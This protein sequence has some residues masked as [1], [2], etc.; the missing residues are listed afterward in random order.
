[1]VLIVSSSMPEKKSR[2]V[3]AQ[4]TINPSSN[5]GQQQSRPTKSTYR[6]KRHVEKS[7]LKTAAAVGHL[8]IA[9]DVSS[10]EVADEDASLQPGTSS[11]DTPTET[12]EKENQK[13]HD[14]QSTVAQSAAT[15]QKPE[16]L[17]T[18]PKHDKIAARL[19]PAAQDSLH[20]RDLK[21]L[22]MKLL[23][24]VE[25]AYRKLE[26]VADNDGVVAANTWAINFEPAYHDLAERM[27]SADHTIQKLEDRL[28]EVTAELASANKIIG[29][30]ESQIP[31]QAGY[32]AAEPII[33]EDEDENTAAAWKARFASM[34]KERDDARAE[35]DVAGE[36]LETAYLIKGDAIK[37]RDLSWKH[38][39]ELNNKYQ[40]LKACISKDK[41]TLFEEKERL[42][43][44]NSQ[45]TE[46]NRDLVEEKDELE[47][48][49]NF[50][51]F[52]N[53]VLAEDLG[54]SWAEAAAPL[55]AQSSPQSGEILGVPAESTQQ[56]LQNKLEAKAAEMAGLE[57]EVASLK[58]DIGSQDIPGRKGAHN[59]K[60]VLLKEK[61]ALG[62]ELQA[63]KDTEISYLQ[64]IKDTQV[65]LH[66]EYRT[67]VDNLSSSVVTTQQ[68]CESA[69]QKFKESDK[70]ISELKKQ[71]AKLDQQAAAAKVKQI[72]D[73]KEIELTGQLNPKLSLQ[74]AE[75]FRKEM[76]EVVDEMATLR[77]KET[78]AKTKEEK[79]RFLARR[80]TLGAR[81][82]ELSSMLLRAPRDS[83]LD[84]K[85]YYT[86]PGIPKT[87]ENIPKTSF[88]S[89]KTVDNIPKVLAD[90]RKNAEQK[91]REGGLI[92]STTAEPEKAS[93]QTSNRAARAAARAGKPV[94]METIGYDTVPAA[95]CYVTL[96]VSSSRLKQ[97][98]L[99]GDEMDTSD[100]AG[101]DKAS[102]S[103]L[104]VG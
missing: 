59:E 56:D 64:A 44:K 45:L 72:Q 93:T 24:D 42:I 35:R 97:M 75:N 49:K 23:K 79:A 3:V 81:N 95:S 68:E 58:A 73:M 7:S 46:E 83:R 20:I 67:T 28:F 12:A 50:F 41:Q 16:G 5:A 86:F 10:A 31:Q 77:D 6:V 27:E 33:L 30:R 82:H 14:P 25:K 85:P 55:E 88:G 98:S 71:I 51:E 37:A 32:S 4:T 84:Q 102:K 22:G 13:S 94:E 36:E 91:A 92:K 76:R 60:E 38:R 21:S 11:N 74:E 78:K 62:D 39:G 17:H 69:K 19:Q 89:P 15:A 70:T 65:D 43:G 80:K 101:P 54:I 40:H 48:Q 104:T 87:V 99:E 29:I 8:N 2:I 18:Y 66:N 103:S 61:Q 26:H 63:A 9:Q 100:R 1:M 90:S 34:K 96:K 47:K 52:K 53:R 57:N